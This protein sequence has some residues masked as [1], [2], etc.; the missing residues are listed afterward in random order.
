MKNGRGD[1]WQDPKITSI[2]AARKKAEQARKSKAASR[3]GIRQK[4]SGGA[5]QLLFGV[6]L[7]A[8]ALGLIVS[9]TRPLWQAAV[10]VGN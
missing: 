1:D 7:V 9:L 4:Q 3:D 5:G 2:S 6:V 10:S 8:M